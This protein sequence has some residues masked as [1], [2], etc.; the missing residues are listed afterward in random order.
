MRITQ[1]DIKLTRSHGALQPF[2]KDLLRR[3]LSG[4]TFACL[5]SGSANKTEP[6]ESSQAD[7]DD[8][9]NTMVKASRDDEAKTRK[10]TEGQGIRRFN[11][12]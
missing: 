6:I 2:L 1:L 8:F 9:G 12:N 3:L 11:F 10:T 4:S 7:V 5:R